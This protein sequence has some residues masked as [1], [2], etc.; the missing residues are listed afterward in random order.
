ML[1]LS[2]FRCSPVYYYIIYIMFVLLLVFVIFRFVVVPFSL[3]VSS[4]F[5]SVTL[6]I[7]FIIIYVCSSVCSFLVLF[8]S[9]LTGS[10][11]CLFA[12]FK[13]ARISIV[14]RETFFVRS[15]CFYY[16]QV[17]KLIVKWFK[18][19]SL[20]FVTAF[21]VACCLLLAFTWKCFIT[22]FWKSL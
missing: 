9:G 11:C 17:T 13:L 6:L 14:S 12:P 1:L 2:V 20:I 4:L 21:S 22:P 3:L 7:Y 8:S 10:F 16:Y 5:L 19:R 18:F 15:S